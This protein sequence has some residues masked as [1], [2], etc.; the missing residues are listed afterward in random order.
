VAD[1]STKPLAVVDIDGVVAD[2]RHRVHYV[3]QRPKDWKRFFAAAVHDDAHPEGLAVIDTLAREHEVVFLTGRPEHLRD[4]TVAWLK[5]HGLDKYRLY[6]RPEGQRGPSARFK[7]DELRRIA[8]HR[9]VAVVVD[10]D[11]LVIEAMRDAG[12][13]TMHADWEQ[14]TAAQQATIV[15]AQELD[16]RT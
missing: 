6:M 7:V 9:R 5:R 14:R 3:E 11:E 10:D 12:Y 4:D 15:D 16:G 2:V 8:K 13:V 1:D